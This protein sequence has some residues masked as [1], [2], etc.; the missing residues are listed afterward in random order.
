[1][2]K[3]MVILFVISASLFAIGSQGFYLVASDVKVTLNEFTTTTDGVDIC[4]DVFEPRYNT[5]VKS[6]VILGHGVVVNKEFMRLI[7]MDLANHNFVAVALDFRGHGKSGGDFNTLSGEGDGGGEFGGPSMSFSSLTNDILAIKYY[8]GNRSDVDIH[9]IGYIG[10]SMGGGAGFKLLSTDNDFKAMVGLA[11]VPD[12]ENTNTTNPRNLLLIVGKYDEAINLEMLMKVMENKTGL[13]ESSINLF[14]QYGSF[15]DGTAAKLYI[16]DNSDHLTA[17][18]DIDFVR[19]I[20][21]W[22]LEALQGIT[23]TQTDFTMYYLQLGMVILSTLAGCLM[24]IPVLDYVIGK[25]SVKK[26]ED[27]PSQKV[28]VKI[29]GKELAKSFFWYVTILSFG[30]IIFALPIFLAPLIFSNVFIALLMGVSMAF[31]FYNRRWHKKSGLKISDVYRKFFSKEYSDPKNIL[32]GLV[33]GII[34]YTIL[35]MSIGN[36]FGIVP[37]NYKLL[38][39]PIYFG[40]IFIVITNFNLFFQPV[41]S[42]KIGYSTPK[43]LI[44]SILVNYG[45]LLSIFSLMIM[46]PSILMGN[47]FIAIVLILAIPIFLVLS[48]ILTYTYSKNRDTMLATTIVSVFLT[49]VFITLS[50]IMSIFSFV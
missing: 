35:V 36:V 45:L 5:S 41:V 33:L 3:S 11:P 26:R 9:N 25:F 13:P 20:R 12:Y 29:T 18:Y 1:M 31:Y 32:V 43:Q 6:A 50:P 48:G 14:Q 23:G 47:Y 2:K 10:Y 34:L 42:E 27:N 24:F 39:S 44:K 37:G 49:F 46:I 15:N 38:F 28:V 30:C 8:L 40:V 19:E 21:T 7:A 4:F 22:M 16:D 17:P